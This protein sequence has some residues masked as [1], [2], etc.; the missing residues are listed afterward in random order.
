MSMENGGAYC[1]TDVAQL[2]NS[3]SAESGWKASHC[4]LANAGSA[5]GRYLCSLIHTERDKSRLGMAEY[6]AI[7]VMA[8]SQSDLTCR[9]ISNQIQVSLNREP[10]KRAIRKRRE[11]AIT[12]PRI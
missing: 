7:S 10:Q 3:G 2:L 5:T 1:P 6:R 8:A 11:A 9:R 4:R 12:V